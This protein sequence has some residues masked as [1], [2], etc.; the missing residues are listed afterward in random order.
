MPVNIQTAAVKSEWP[1]TASLE[2]M[3]VVDIRA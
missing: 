3:A 1:T 2:T